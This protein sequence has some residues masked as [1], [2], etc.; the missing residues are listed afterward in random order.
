ML[1]CKTLGQE[2]A[3]P[4]MDTMIMFMKTLGM[5]ASCPLHTM[6]PDCHGLCQD[7]C[8]VLGLVSALQNGDAASADYCL[9]RLTCKK[10]CHDVA[11]AAGEFAM[12]LRGAGCTLTPLSKEMLAD[13]VSLSSHAPTIH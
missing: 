5:C 13:I 7:E 12:T 3:R 4:C 10:R 2:K 9:T 1:F 8:L 11:F 6:E